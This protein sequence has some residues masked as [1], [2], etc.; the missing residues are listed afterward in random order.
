MVFF[1]ISIPFTKKNQTQI[2]K[3]IDFY[4][5]I[6]T[7]LEKR[8]GLCVFWTY[9]HNQ[10]SEYLKKILFSYPVDT[11]YLQVPFTKKFQWSL[12]KLVNNNEL[13]IS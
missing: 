2:V 13:G 1:W 6:E 11:H 12:K 4:F 5:R 7:Y 8:L 9:K 3:I 10:T